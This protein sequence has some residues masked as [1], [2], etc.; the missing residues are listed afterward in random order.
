MAAIAICSRR[1]SVWNLLVGFEMIAVIMES[2]FEFLAAPSFVLQ[3]WGR[4][5]L[6]CFILALQI[7]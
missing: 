6:Y 2:S 5:L 3:D 1:R 7:A 4:G